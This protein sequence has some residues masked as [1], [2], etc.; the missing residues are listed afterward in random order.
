M[1]RKRNQQGIFSHEAQGYSRP[2]RSRAEETYGRSEEFGN[3]EYNTRSGNPNRTLTYPLSENE[4]ADRR[5]GYNDRSNFD[6]Y[7]DDQLERRSGWP[8]SREQHQNDYYRQGYGHDNERF[9]NSI[10]RD[11]ERSERNGQHK[12]KGPKGYQRSDERI[13]E[14]IHDRLTDDH[15]IDAS[16]IEVNVSNGEVSLT[17]T[18]DDRSAK[19]RAEDISE[20]VSGVHNVENRLR[21]AGHDAERTGSREMQSGRSAESSSRTRKQDK[22]PITGMDSN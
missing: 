13:R 12:G 8:E 22:L 3:E 21:I 20:N 15:F 16:N 19:R 9:G 10:F 18:V 4:S 2:M 7:N 17:G 6:R 1:N 14:D 11:Q 5:H